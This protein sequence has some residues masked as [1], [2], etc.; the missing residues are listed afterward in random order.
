MVNFQLAVFV[1]FGALIHAT[2]R[3]MDVQGL[4]A[5]LPPGVVES[6]LAQNGISQEEA[7]QLLESEQGQQAVQQVMLGQ[8]SVDEIQQTTQDLIQQS[9]QPEQQDAQK[10][11]S[12]DSLPIGYLYQQQEENENEA[13]T[14]ISPEY[15]TTAYQAVAPDFFSMSNVQDE[16]SYSN[17][18]STIVFDEKIIANQTTSNNVTIVKAIEQIV[19][20]VANLL[21]VMEDMNEANNSSSYYTPEMED[22]QEN[23]QEEHSLLELQAPLQET[24]EL[25]DLLTSVL[26]QTLCLKGFT[27]AECDQDSSNSTLDDK[28]NQNE[29]MQSQNV[30]DEDDH[31]YL[32]TPLVFLTAFILVLTIQTEAIL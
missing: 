13:E 23:I 14:E 19:T 5:Q 11:I 25:V 21:P 12:P 26:Q 31:G 6:F 32:Q 10:E 22:L 18:D 1:V 4:M 27:S 29:R 8:M 15:L 3:D 24:S 30:E 7:Q 2:L 17:N 16:Y 20:I 28:D 9:N